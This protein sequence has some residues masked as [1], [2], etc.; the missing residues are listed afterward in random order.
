MDQTDFTTETQE[1]QR[2]QRNPFLAKLLGWSGKQKP[3]PR[4]DKN[5]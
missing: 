2:A 3:G 5:G 1:T 4:K